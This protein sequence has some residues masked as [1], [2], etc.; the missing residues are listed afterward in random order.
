VSGRVHGH[1]GDRDLH[2]HKHIDHHRDIAVSV[3]ITRY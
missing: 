1:D 2:F 3:E